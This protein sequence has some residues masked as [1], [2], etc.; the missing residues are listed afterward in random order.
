MAHPHGPASAID[1]TNCYRLI[2]GR[3]PENSQVVDEKL[4]QDF[5]DVVRAF[6]S[7]GE[8]ADNVF[9]PMMTTSYWPPSLF[10]GTLDADLVAWI[11]D[12]FLA[13]VDRDALE[14]GGS[15]YQAQRLMLSRHT[16]AHA[17]DFAAWS[18]SLPSYMSALAGR[19][20]SPATLVGAVDSLRGSVV[21]GWVYDPEAPDDPATVEFLIDGVVVHS[22]TASRYRADIVEAGLGAGIAGFRT[23]L[24][25]PR[26]EGKPVLVH[27]RL[28]GTKLGLAN[29][30]QYT[31]ASFPTKRWLERR[32]RVTG[33]FLE[34]LRRRLDRSTEPHLLSIVMPVYNVRA[35]WLHEAIDSVRAQWCTRWELICVDD[36]SSEPHIAEILSDYVD[37]DPR[38]RVVRLPRNGGIS[39]ATNAGI[40]AAGGD[41]IAFMD[42]DDLL[43]PDAVF[44]LLRGAKTGA[45]LIYTDELLTGEEPDDLHDVQAR[46]AFS[47]D[48]YLSH[49]YFVHM[50]AARATIVRAI[51]GLDEAMTISADV[52]FVLR[53]LERSALVAHVPV[54]AYRWRTHVSSAGH[55]RI[56]HVTDATVGALN[57]HLSRVLPGATACATPLFNHHRAD[58]PDAPGAV[59][60]IIPTK[61][62][63]DLVRMCVESLRA[64][65]ERSDLTICVVDHQ[66]DDPATQAY[67]DEIRHDCLVIPYEG[68]F[69]YPRINNF[70]VRE[71]SRMLGFVPPYLLFCNNDVEAIADGWLERMRS[72]A[73][74][75]D[76]GI[77]GTNLLYPNDDVQH[78]GVI[79]G[80]N[81]AAEHAHKFVPYFEASGERNRSY[82]GGLVSTRNYSAVTAACMMMRST[83]FEQVGGF[84]ERFAI[85][86]N[87]TDLCLRVG[88]LGYNIVNDAETAFYHHESAT[89]SQ[90]N[91]TKHAADDDLLKSRWGAMIAAGDPFHNPLFS[92]VGTGHEVARYSSMRQAIRLRPGVAALRERFHVQPAVDQPERV[93][94]VGT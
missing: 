53:A 77:V 84:D 36:Y 61:N 43:E 90:T 40:A 32:A 39:R 71:A 34:R 19:A 7:S 1:I 94:P 82:L 4:G 8:F 12:R 52:D 5:A 70:A 86:F 63:G 37:R 66:S 58:F 73:G 24:P 56:G 38:V 80:I 35:D 75:G 76:V 17:P 78:S 15:W 93:A 81:T 46:P 41:Y 25:L 9:M 28:E 59:L 64:T 33:P 18:A 91:Q 45:D 16:P 10:G 26:L 72:I 60:A 79:V 67:L 20:A 89:R 88:A 2:L 29:A 13:D 62:H 83:I 48:F 54:I 74:R 92:D 44:H 50:I 22:V 87:D 6:L 55:A 65:S 3:Q 30:P 68:A 51:G 85:G 42:H 14:P 21:S 69:N 47:W 49:P 31:K 11:S 57:R 27:A 23:E